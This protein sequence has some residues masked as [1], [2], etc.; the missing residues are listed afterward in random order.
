M[1]ITSVLNK[2]KGKKKYLQIGT[3]NLGLTPLYAAMIGSEVELTEANPK[4]YE[5]ILENLNFNT[6]L[7]AKITAHKTCLFGSKKSPNRQINL[8]YP[9]GNK[10]VMYSSYW[11]KDGDEEPWFTVCTPFAKWSLM[12]GIGSP[13]LINLQMEGSELVLLPE[14]IKFISKLEKKKLHQ[15]IIPSLLFPIDS[16]SFD[17]KDSSNVHYNIVSL[18]KLYPFAYSST[19]NKFKSST[20]IDKNNEDETFDELVPEPLSLPLSIENVCS[21]C[22]YLFSF[23]EIT[24]WVSP[25]HQLLKR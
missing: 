7:K 9:K 20:E 25:I 23:T 14:I 4:A 10:K 11:G 16:N 15:S 1:A 6:N 19:S 18:S 24:E 17:P 12:A 2:N 13:N 22:Y 5:Q 21:N 8:Y 3:K